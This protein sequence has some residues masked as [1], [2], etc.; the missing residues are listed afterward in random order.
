MT[1]STQLDRLRAVAAPAVRSAGLVL[2]DVTLTPV[3]RRRLLRVVVDLDA[4][5]AGAV[6]VE[7]VT[8]ATHALSQAL[9]ASEVMGETPYVLEVTSPGAD[10]PLTT[11][12]HW[13]RARGRLV[14]AELGDGRS[15]VGRLGTVDADGVVLGGERFGWAVLASGRVELEFNRPD[16]EPGDA[17]GGAS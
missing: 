15:L 9:D 6:G 16:D 2:E 7:A 12:R 11:H 1:T 3:G 8:A 5:V 14:R 17:D 13:S 10:R 4:D